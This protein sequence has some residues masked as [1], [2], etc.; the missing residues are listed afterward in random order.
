M[1]NLNFSFTTHQFHHVRILRATITLED[2]GS[3]LLILL[4]IPRAKNLLLKKRNAVYHIVQKRNLEGYRL[5]PT[6]SLVRLCNK[7]R[8][9]IPRC[10]VPKQSSQRNPLPKKTRFLKPSRA[11]TPHSQPQRTKPMQMT[12]GGKDPALGKR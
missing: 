8:R 1:R 3:L 12:L 9:K 5:S 11:E 10:P 4:G 7:K 2:P 6:S